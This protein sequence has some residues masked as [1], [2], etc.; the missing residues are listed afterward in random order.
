MLL[1]PGVPVL[2]PADGLTTPGPPFSPLTEEP[3]LEV[4]VPRGGVSGA[5]VLAHH[6]KNVFPDASILRGDPDLYVVIAALK[7]NGSGSADGSR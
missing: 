1:P 6:M 3:E 4:P 2:S 5:V 7:G